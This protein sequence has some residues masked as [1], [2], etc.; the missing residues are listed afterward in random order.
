MELDTKTRTPSELLGL[1][2]SK[3]PN[4]AVAVAAINVLTSIIRHS[5]ATTLMELEID[6]KAAIDNLKTQGSFSSISLSAGCELFSRYVTRTYT[7]IPDF[8]QCKE[9]IIQRGQE[10]AQIAAGS[11]SDIAA[12]MY[13]F[14]SED[15]VILIHGYSRVVVF[16]L[17]NAAKR[18]RFFRV[19]TTQGMPDKA[20]E[21]NVKAL[22]AAGIP[23][24]LILDS[25]VGHYIERA[26]LVLFGA[27]GVMEN[28]GVINKVGS[29]QIAVVAKAMKVPVYVCAESY[30]F[31]RLYPLKQSDVPQT[32]KILKGALSTEDITTELKLTEKEKSN[33]TVWDPSCDYTPPEYI[34]LLFTDLGI[35][36]PSAVS[37]E[38]IKLY[39]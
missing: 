25:A 22:T 4:T 37:D 14:V 38:L 7:D 36:T 29:F 34:T 10:F 24:T 28:G 6:L 18:G 27:D 1:I 11:K 32:T 13:R 30:K 19:V 9:R 5:A 35:L 15:K 33:F 26:D 20:G 3:D 17:V 31:A 21:Q 23:V 16:A 39:L 2:L 12:L 8:F